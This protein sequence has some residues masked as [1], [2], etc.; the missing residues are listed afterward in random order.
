MKNQGNSG[1]RIKKVSDFEKHQFCFR[2]KLKISE[3]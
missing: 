1:K 3:E 2:R